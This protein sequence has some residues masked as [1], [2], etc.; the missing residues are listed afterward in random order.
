M[1]LGFTGTAAEL[2]DALDQVVADQYTLDADDS[3]EDERGIP[4]RASKLTPLAFCIAAWVDGCDSGV[5][6]RLR[7]NDLVRLSIK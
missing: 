7:F 3:V 6:F 2:R 1:S 5:E 4:G